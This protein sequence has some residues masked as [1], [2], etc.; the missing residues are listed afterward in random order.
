MSITEL[1]NRIESTQPYLFCPK[2]LNNTTTITDITFQNDQIL[3]VMIC[4]YQKELITN[5]VNH[6][7]SIAKNTMTSEI[8]EKVITDLSIHEFNSISSLQHYISDT[9]FNI[10]KIKDQY[11]DRIKSSNIQSKQKQ[12]TIIEQE[13]QRNESINLQCYK[14]LH[15]LLYNYIIYK[16]DEEKKAQLNNLFKKFFNPYSSFHQ[17]Y[18]FLETELTNFTDYL[19]YTFFL[20]FKENEC[21]FSQ[22]KTIKVPYEEV[23]QVGQNLYY[24][25]LLVPGRPFDHQIIRTKSKAH[26]KIPGSSFDYG[27]IQMNEHFVII[28]MKECIEIFD[29]E[30]EQN[31]ITY[32]KKNKNQEIMHIGKITSGFVYIYDQTD[33]TFFYC[34]KSKFFKF[35]HKQSITGTYPYYCNKEIRGVAT[36]KDTQILYDD[37]MTIKLFDVVKKEVIKIYETDSFVNDIVPLAYN[38]FIVTTSKTKILFYKEEEKKYVKMIRLRTI[39]T[40]CCVWTMEPLDIDVNFYI[41]VTQLRDGRILLQM[42]KNIV[43]VIDGLSFDDLYEFTLTSFFTFNSRDNL[44]QIPDGRLIYT[45]DTELY[46]VNIKNFEIKKLLDIKKNE[47]DDETIFLFYPNNVERELYI[48]SEYFTFVIKEHYN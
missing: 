44:K 46:T 2:C 38:R 37:K 7:Y 8:R 24:Q 40:P 31:V 42:E 28:N 13:Y 10:N 41:G 47:N 48:S 1:I 22:I 15:L 21:Q 45:S 9:L 29:L 4:H 5:T 16:E 23:L 30:T 34:P 25:C 32:H 6:Y 27:S 17:K 3:F 14:V 12:I 18:T 19:H 39:S 36:Y 11:I 26:I 33:I 35:W 43:K 20:Y